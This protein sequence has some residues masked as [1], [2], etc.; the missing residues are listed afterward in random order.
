MDCP[1]PIFHLFSL[2]SNKKHYYVNSRPLEQEWVSRPLCRPPRMF[3]NVWLQV[4]ANL[5]LMYTC[6]SSLRIPQWTCVNA[7]IG[8]FLSLQKCN[9]LLQSAAEN[10]DSV[11]EPLGIPSMTSLLLDFLSPL[12]VPSI[13]TEVL[14][15]ST[16]F[17]PV[18][19]LIHT[20]RS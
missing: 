19:N 17:E 6:C 12:F 9:C 11:N 8:V 7:E 3:L 16:G 1:R 20:L 18:A 2:V 4:V 14:S 5:R 15:L 13:L 10:A